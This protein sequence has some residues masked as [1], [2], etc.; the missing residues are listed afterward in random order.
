MSALALLTGAVQ[1]TVRIKQGAWTPFNPM[2]EELLVRTVVDTSLLRPDMF[3]LTF[4]DRE[5]TAL[6]RSRITI[7]TEVEVSAGRVDGADDGRGDLDRGR[8]RPPR[9]LHGRARVRA[10]APAAAGTAQPDVREL[11]GRCHRRRAIAKEAGLDDRHR[12]GSGRH[13]PL[14]RPGRPDRLGVPARARPSRSATRRA[15][16]TASSTSAPHRACPLVGLAGASTPPRRSAVGL[17]DTN[18]PRSARTCAGCARGSA[19]PA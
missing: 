5:G 6:E 7:G 15:S 2:V 14:R 4:L 3:E 12:R 17:G 16:P 13:P 1:A 10:D 19:R 18:A 11:D 8:L 9:P